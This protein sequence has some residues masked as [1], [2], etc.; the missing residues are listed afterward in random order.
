MEDHIPICA[1]TFIYFGKDGRALHG[2]GSEEEIL[3]KVELWM[4][5]HESHEKFRVVQ[6]WLEQRQK[7]VAEAEEEFRVRTKREDL[8]Q[9][10]DKTLRKNA[11]RDKK[12]ADVIRSAIF[13]KNGIPPQED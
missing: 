13:T 12:L 10:V 6:A 8:S 7:Q 4:G 5:E 1:G 11:V 3:Q 2:G 9:R